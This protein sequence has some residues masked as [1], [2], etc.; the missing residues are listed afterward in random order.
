MGCGEQAALMVQNATGIHFA[1]TNQCD[2]ARE[3][4]SALQLSPLFSSAVCQFSDISSLLQPWLWGDLGYDEQ[5]KASRGQNCRPAAADLDISGPHCTDSKLGRKA[6]KDGPTARF[7]LSYMQELRE[8]RTKLAV[9]ENVSSGDFA[10]MLTDNLRDIY[11]IEEIRTDPRDVGYFAVSRPRS[12]FIL[13][14]REQG[15]FLRSP[16]SVY[17]EICSTLQQQKDLRIPHLFWERDEMELRR[18]RFAS[19]PQSRSDDASGSAF[20]DQLP[21][22]ECKQLEG[23]KRMWKEHCSD[24]PADEALFVLNQDC[25]KYTKWTL[26]GTDKEA[27]R[28]PTLVKGCGTT[29]LW[30]MQSE[31]WAT[32][33]EKL[34]TRIDAACKANK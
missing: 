17:S 22:F 34:R 4:F 19:I 32:A 25:Q 27:G 21:P 8:R 20:S 12:Y 3:A 14:H 10:T 16:R 33:R 23:Y 11:Y 28:C 26:Y 18:E 5:V 31:R 6:G 15:R 29:R 30:H 7:F 13:F 24:K 1:L 2:H 9:I